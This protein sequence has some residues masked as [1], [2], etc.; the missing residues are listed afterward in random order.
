LPQ[1]A[2]AGMTLVELLVVVAIITML[3]A[4]LLPAVQ[5]VRET[6][7]RARCSN[8]VKQLTTAALGHVQ[9]QG[10]FPSGGWGYFWVGDPDRGFG[11]SQPGGWIYSSLPY[12]E[13]VAVFNLP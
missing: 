12:L 5:S 6:A 3:M 7:R 9:A 13:Q 8:N 11:E 10:Y 4:L 2:A 1:L